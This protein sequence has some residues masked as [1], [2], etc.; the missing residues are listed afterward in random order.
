MCLQTDLITY[1][2]EGGIDYIEEAE[3]EE[4]EKE[5]EPLTLFDLICVQPTRYLKKLT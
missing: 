3:I 5:I 4:E 2:Y 1:I